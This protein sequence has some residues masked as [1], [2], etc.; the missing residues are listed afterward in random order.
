MKFYREKRY[1]EQ[2][3]VQTYFSTAAHRHVGAGRASSFFIARR[4]CDKILR[5]C[6]E[7]IASNAQT[8]DRDTKEHHLIGLKHPAPS[9]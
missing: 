4:D 3:L 8:D 9:L 5:F 2:L 7:L 1:L 6:A